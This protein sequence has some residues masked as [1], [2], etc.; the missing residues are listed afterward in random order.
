MMLAI[1]CAA[2]EQSASSLSQC[3]QEL[4]QASSAVRS[5]QRTIGTAYGREHICRL[6]GAADA[7]DAQAEKVLKLQEA[8]QSVLREY[9][10][11]E[12]RLADTSQRQ[13]P[14][15]AD[16]ASGISRPRP[17]AEPVAHPGTAADEDNPLSKAVFDLYSQDGSVDKR[18]RTLGYE[19]SGSGIEAYGFKLTGADEMLLGSIVVGTSVGVTGVAIRGS[20]SEAWDSFGSSTKTDV[21]TGGKVTVKPNSTDPEDVASL[22]EYDGTPQKKN[23]FNVINANVSA[24][25]GATA[26]AF[27]YTTAIGS[28][29]ICGTVDANLKLLDADI[30][31]ALGASYGEDGLAVLGKAEVGVSLAEIEGSVSANVKGVEAQATVSAEVGFGASFEAGYKDGTFSL[32]LGAALGVGG[33]VAFK[34]KLPK[35]W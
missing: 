10:E 33:K 13:I 8:A 24:S 31:A 19:H 34:I 9:W 18:F 35:L 11:L 6:Q 12:S 2:L 23:K 27:D 30:G 4:E 17:G 26:A 7:I 5:I 16:R 29:D 28:D 21:K 32:E 1:N 20:K 15:N 14:V 22:T 25:I 3:A